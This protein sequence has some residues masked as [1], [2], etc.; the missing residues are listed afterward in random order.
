MEP[1]GKTSRHFAIP[2]IRNLANLILFNTLERSNVMTERCHS[3]V[4]FPLTKLA[5]V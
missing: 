3:L 1:H 2:T 5:L 4:G